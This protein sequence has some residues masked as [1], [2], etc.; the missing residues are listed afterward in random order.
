MQYQLSV[1]AIF[2]NESH[3]MKE[4]IEHYIH[5]GVE[6][7]YLI[8]DNSTDDFETVLKEYID[9]GIIE[10]FHVIEPYYLGR[11][12]A[13]YNRFILPRIKES[14]WLLMV[15]LDEYVWSKQG[16]DLRPVLQTF[17]SY[18]QIQLYEGLFGSNGFIT[19]P[20]YLLPNFVKRAAE[21][22]RGKYKYFVNTRFEF[23]S[24]NIHHADFENIEY[25]EDPDVFI[26]A[27]PEYFVINHY[28]C[29]SRDFWRETKCTRGDADDYLVRT[30]EDFALY[31][32]NELYDFEL[33][34]QNK[35]IYKNI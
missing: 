27:F 6:H 4:W 12:R 30:Y 7:F 32:T 22:R 1:G 34:E 29:Q 18:G 5:H 17:E 21:Y 24:L 25:M 19:Q 28:N 35:S 13:L 3:S 8:N 33:Y 20:K 26:L 31:D 16:I 11:Q 14:K 23:S 9:K 2:K 15:D 10:L